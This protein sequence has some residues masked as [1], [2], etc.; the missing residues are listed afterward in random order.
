MDSQVEVEWYPGNVTQVVRGVRHRVL[1]RGSEPGRTQ[2]Y[3]TGSIPA[4]PPL[5]QQV[6]EEYEN[7]CPGQFLPRADSTAQAEGNQPVALVKSEEGSSRGL[8]PCEGILVGLVMCATAGHQ[9][10]KITMVC[11]YTNLLI[12]YYN[13]MP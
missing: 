2:G 1:H 6:S 9:K 12:F 11:F 5:L 13:L 7:L 3:S 4:L 8:S 10:P